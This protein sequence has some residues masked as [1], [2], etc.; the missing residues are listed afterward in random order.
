MTAKQLADKH[1]GYWEGQHPA[2][3]IGDWKTEVRDG[4]TRAGYWEWIANQIEADQVFDAM[5]R[6][7]GLEGTKA[8]L[9]ACTAMLSQA[10]DCMNGFNRGSFLES[11]EVQ[12]YLR[13]YL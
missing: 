5:E 11:D 9:D 1:G 13:E 8:Q 4:Y 12:E 2:Y 7:G 10:L 3:P 6:H